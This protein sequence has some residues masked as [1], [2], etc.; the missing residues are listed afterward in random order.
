M[1]RITW[2]F[3]LTSFWITTYG[4]AIHPGGIAGMK[5]WLQVTTDNP[6]TGI[7]VDSENGE[8]LYEGSLSFINHRPGILWQENTNIEIPLDGLKGSDLT[9]FTVYH[10]SSTEEQCIYSL[11][12]QKDHQLLLTSHRFADLSAVNYMN[13]P[14]VNTRTPQINTYIHSQQSYRGSQSP[15]ILRIGK[16]PIY[17]NLPVS[18][19]SG[20]FYEMIIYDRTL[21][22]SEK[23]QVESYLAIKYG[24]TLRNA[25]GAY[26]DLYGQP[27]WPINDLADFNK[28]ITVIGIDPS[29]NFSQPSST[30]TETT[31]F[32]NLAF[33]SIDE[34]SSLGYK[35]MRSN[36]GRKALDHI[37]SEDV[38]K[39]ERSWVI[40][41][42]GNHRKTD[43][44]WN[45]GDLEL[46]KDGQFWLQV[47]RQGTESNDLSSLDFFRADQKSNR[48]IFSNIIWDI[49]GSG[50]D[51][52]S[53]IEAPEMYAVM[54][55]R[56][57]SCT[58]NE[59][60]IPY[61][62]IGGN[63][64][65]N[66]E[67]YNEDVMVD[68]QVLYNHDVAE[69]KRLSQGKYEIKIKDNRGSTYRSSFYQ[70]GFNQE[71]DHLPSTEYLIEGKEL[72]LDFGSENKDYNYQWFFGG[73]QVSSTSD[74]SITEAGV[75]TLVIESKGCKYWHTLHVK[76]TESYVFQDIQLFPNPTLDGYF[77]VEIDLK[78]ESPLWMTISDIQ[79][80]VIQEKYLPINRTHFVH[81][82]IS[83]PGLYLLSFRS[84]EEVITRKFVVK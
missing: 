34:G 39:M 75:Y 50:S 36:G 82:H 29:N 68:N 37:V 51:V 43:L 17:H 79:G 83:A 70:Q 2:I 76:D 48:L 16:K 26:T 31:G 23:H 58:D 46:N 64:P 40:H 9:I 78:K 8:P 66:V 22:P 18:G 5:T 6:H 84:E 33:S 53:I 7:L 49:D 11:D 12:S 20:I 63:P 55:H 21:S 4:Q 13:F 67:V 60:A 72:N 56:Q 42:T 30:S 35:S 28:N 73:N 65:F 81:G 59:S 52:F 27:L 41:A 24:L 80:K 44:S 71:I 47:N 38:Y 3:A 10:L 14:V 77:Q 57:P 15:E 45:Q 61:R 25:I 74:I 62:I 1:K 69:L 19:F 54:D 32:L